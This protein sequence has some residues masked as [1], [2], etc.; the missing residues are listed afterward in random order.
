MVFTYQHFKRYKKTM[1]LISAQ[2]RS[3]GCTSFS[4]HFHG[5]LKFFIFL[6]AF[7]HF[8]MKF[9]RNVLFLNAFPAFER[10][11]YLWQTRTEVNKKLSESRKARETDHSHH[12][13]FKKACKTSGFHTSAFENHWFYKL[14]IAAVVKTTG[15]TSFS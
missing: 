11:S 9:Y 15:F 7:A 10:I 1:D 13:S 2:A 5:I 14:S 6:L 12:S 8:P 4:I 3:I